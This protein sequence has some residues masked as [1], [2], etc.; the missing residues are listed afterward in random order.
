VPRAKEIVF[1]GV[2]RQ[3]I[4]V[5]GA[6][7]NALGILAGALFGF[8][9]P[10]P[11]STRVQQFFKS[12][13]GVLTF[14][15]GLVLVWLNINGTFGAGVKQLFLALLAVVLG[16]WLGRLLRLQKISNRIGRHAAGLIASA[17]KHPPGRPVDGIV[18][19]T[20]L[21]CAAPLGLIGAVTDG[22]NFFFYL[23]ALKAV[24]DGLAMISF[25]KIFRWPVALA[26]I[27]V[28]IF[29]NSLTLAVHLY[30]TPYLDT[31][32][33]INAISATAGFIVCA[34]ALVIFE[35][36]RVELAN[37]LP[38]LVIAPLLAKLLN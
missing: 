4:P 12:A 23:L 38:A 32:H 35:I 6:F 22:L 19:A 18:A 33:W 31:H 8:T 24:M 13:L 10:Q 1:F 9:H 17:Q 20:L 11:L 34:T 21:F 5:I 25:V 28:L 26:A 16:N 37:Y 7:L 15:C 29:L 27:P 30:A 36:R 3:N 2:S 14:V